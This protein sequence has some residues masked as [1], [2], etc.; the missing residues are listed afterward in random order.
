MILVATGTTGYDPLAREMDRLAPSLGETV[1]IQCGKSRYIPQ[2][3]L[4]FRFAPS[5]EPYYEQAS[6][7]VSHGGMGICLEVLAAGKPLIAVDNPDRYDQHQTDLLSALAA[8]NYLIWCKEIKGLRQAIER[9]RRTTL[10]R[11]ELPECHI[12]D[13]I[14][15]LLD[16]LPQT[17]ASSAR[18][19][20]HPVA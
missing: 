9:I 18:G 14:R 17:E 15:E 5:L 12:A 2:N 10:R 16:G 1:V 20:R 8:Q 6:L 7:V 11:Y 19:S 13:Y 3:A 4:R